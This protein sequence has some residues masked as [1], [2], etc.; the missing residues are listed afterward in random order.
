[1][2]RHADW[3]N[4]PRDVLRTILHRTLQ[5]PLPFAGVCKSWRWVLDDEAHR[6]HVILH[7]SPVREHSLQEAMRSFSAFLCSR[8]PTTTQLDVFVDGAD[9]CASSACLASAAL[10]AVLLHL[11]PSLRELVLQ[12]AAMSDAL[13]GCPFLDVCDRLEFVRTHVSHELDACCLRSLQRVELVFSGSQASVKLPLGL[14]SCRFEVHD[15]APR[16]VLTQMLALLPGMP[17][18]RTLQMYTDYSCALDVARLSPSLSTLL[19]GGSV[20]TD[21]LLDGA[22]CTGMEVLSLHKCR[23]SSLDLARFVSACAGLKAVAF[24][25]YYVNDDARPLLDLGHA[26]LKAVALVS[27]PYHPRLRCTLPRGIRTLTLGCDDIDDVVN[28]CVVE[29]SV[30]QLYL[31]DMEHMPPSLFDLAW[32]RALAFPR[33]RDVRVS[34]CASTRLAGLLGQRCPRAALSFEHGPMVH[35]VELDLDLLG[36]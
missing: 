1:M 29:S 8:P 22:R 4:L 18:L 9:A 17:R 13:I 35:D 3:A 32:P 34:G 26:P 24:V 12:P 7:H 21:V 23:V 28:Q 2:T 14:V 31:S 10:G 19:V 6:R 27:N 30:E 5:N 15:T 20:A 16:H 36:E 11:A 33:L 25:D